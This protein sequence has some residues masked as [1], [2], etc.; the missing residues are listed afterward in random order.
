MIRALDF[1]VKDIGATIKKFI[2]IY[3]GILTILLEQNSNMS[4][5]FLLINKHT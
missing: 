1:K 2:I 4:G 5:K 3:E